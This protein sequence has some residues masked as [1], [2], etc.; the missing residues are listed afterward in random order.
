M[1]LLPMKTLILAIPVILL[2]SCTSKTV[3]ERK[4]IDPGP[5]TLVIHG[6][7]GTILRE[8][9]TPEKEKA[10]HEGLSQALESGY[11]VLATGGK[12]IDA[13]I[14]AIRVLEDNPLFNAGR[15]SV[16]TA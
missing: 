8:N 10:Y 9:M 5:I 3:P 15:G 4:K 13:V 1:I 12:S 6:G 2:I 14:A 11:A 7:A 16:F